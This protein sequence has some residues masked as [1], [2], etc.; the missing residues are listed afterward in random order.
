MSELGI[1]DPE[2]YEKFLYGKKGSAT[3]MSSTKGKPKNP[4]ESN[5]AA[6]D[7][8]CKSYDCGAEK[9]KSNDCAMAI[10]DTI[11]Q[12][13]VA[14][15]ALKDIS[16]NYKKCG[17][18]DA[19]KAIVAKNIPLITKALDS[20]ETAL[21]DLKPKTTL[22]FNANPVFYDGEQYS[23]AL[24]NRI[25][26][27]GYP[28]DEA[29]ELNYVRKVPAKNMAGSKGKP[30]TPYESNRAAGDCCNT[31]TCAVASAGSCKVATDN[32]IKAARKFVTDAVEPYGM[33]N[34]ELF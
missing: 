23:N 7:D 33:I 14:R 17:I 2:E 12:I 28:Q 13:N 25:E 24:T 8:C 31:F 3:P 29:N 16:E 22:F 27:N 21:T 26:T 4:Y 5:R 15:S 34:D 9:T 20:A 6:G 1:Q 10:G 11:K 32:A 18:D 19:K 30:R